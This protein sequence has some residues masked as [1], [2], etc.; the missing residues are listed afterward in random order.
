MSE[1]IRNVLIVLVSLS[2]I[3]AVVMIDILVFGLGNTLA[4]VAMALFLLGALSSMAVGAEYVRVS[5]K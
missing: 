2:L 3:C 4:A 1:L 5:H